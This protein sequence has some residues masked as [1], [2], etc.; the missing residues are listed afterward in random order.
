[1]ALS[2]DSFELNGRTYRI[3]TSQPG[4]ASHSHKKRNWAII[5]GGT[6]VGTAFGA[7]AGGGVGALVGAGAGAAAGTAGAAITGKKEV[8]LPV[9]SPL[10]FVL[11]QPVTVAR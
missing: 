9:E 7:I 4:V 1:M 2:L 3:A 6:G 11:Q 8:S 10:Q 5:G